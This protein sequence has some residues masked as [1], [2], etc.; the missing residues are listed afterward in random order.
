MKYYIPTDAILLF[1]ELI[2]KNSHINLSVNYGETDFVAYTD[3]NSKNCYINVTE[4]DISGK[5]PNIN[6]WRLIASYTKFANGCIDNGNVFP[7][8]DKIFNDILSKSFPNIPGEYYILYNTKLCEIAYTQSLKQ[9]FKRDISEYLNY[10]KSVKEILSNL[11][12][13][14][15]VYN[16]KICHKYLLYDFNDVLAHTLYLLT[17][18]S[19][20]N[21]TTVYESVIK[22]TI[23]IESIPNIKT[24]IDKCM[25]ILRTN[26][27][28]LANI[29]S[30]LD[31]WM[32]IRDDINTIIDF[33]RH[34]L[35]NCIYTAYFGEVYGRYNLKLFL[36]SSKS[37]NHGN[38]K[39]YVSVLYRNN[40]KFVIFSGEN[41]FGVTTQV[42]GREC[43]IE[44]T[45][46]KHTTYFGG[47]QTYLK[48]VVVK[49]F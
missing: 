37:Y 11:I 28:E 13:D 35:E 34:Y 2:K 17:N 45:V 16:D 30:V 22:D 24:H 29:K 4:V 33:C 31:K 15:N 39:K 46:A 25:Q 14:L 41:L 10:Y 40:V 26:A 18:D 12:A 27:E 47:A 21:S 49:S 3:A 23:D 42:D 19:R 38:S 6:N 9:F 1:N 7:G 20:V 8:G 36:M 43:Y 5:L 48:D 32:V 44:A